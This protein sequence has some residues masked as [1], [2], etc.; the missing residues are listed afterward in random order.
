MVVEE[1]KNNVYKPTDGQSNI[2]NVDEH[3]NGSEGEKTTDVNG[4]T[5]GWGK[6]NKQVQSLFAWCSELEPGQNRLY[7]ASGSD[8]LWHDTRGL[9]HQMCRLVCCV[10]FCYD[11]VIKSTRLH[12]RDIL[13]HIPQDCF[14][15]MGTI[16]R[17]ATLEDV[18]KF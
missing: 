4:V 16:V 11:Y 10:L 6:K 2:E 18:G 3:T 9:P 13:T 5:D 15:D 7:V 14:T 12:S 1:V 17:D 8:T